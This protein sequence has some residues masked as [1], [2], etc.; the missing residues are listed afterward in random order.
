M[1]AANLEKLIGL[2]ASLLVSVFV[3]GLAAS[4]SSGA[5]GFWGG[6]PFW[7]ICLTILPLLFYDFW[8][9]CLKNKDN[10]NGNG[11]SV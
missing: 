2:F 8:D 3:L 1:S 11:N 4:I 7:V 5:A 9:S 6:L 10:G